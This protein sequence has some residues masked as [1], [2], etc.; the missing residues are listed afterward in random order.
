MEI[1]KT[2][3]LKLSRVFILLCISTTLDLLVWC[4]WLHS[5]PAKRFTADEIQTA[6]SL[7]VM[8][9]VGICFVHINTND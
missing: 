5:L 9:A 7:C 8:Q 1:L 3:L 4:H 6:F 2:H